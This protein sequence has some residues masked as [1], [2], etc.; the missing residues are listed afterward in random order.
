M[1]RLKKK[2]PA[3]LSTIPLSLRNL[4]K[5]WV[6]IIAEQKYRL[7]SAKSFHFSLPLT[8]HLTQKAYIVYYK[9]K[10][11]CIIQKPKKVIFCKTPQKLLWISSKH[12]IALL[13][14]LYQ[15]TKNVFSKFVAAWGSDKNIGAWCDFYS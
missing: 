15:Q 10:M 6:F 9:K 12:Y 2:Y 7:Y 1:Y 4:V 13:I 14:V 3:T 11:P 5:T 8:I